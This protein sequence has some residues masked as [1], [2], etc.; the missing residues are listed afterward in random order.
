MKA[1]IVVDIPVNDSIEINEY[2]MV[3]DLKIR[4]MTLTDRKDLFI[5]MK[6]VNLKPMPEKKDTQKWLYLDLINCS[7]SHTDLVCAYVGY[8]KCI[9]EILGEEE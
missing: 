7:T 2:G 5:E 6:E 8:N 1:L 4:P 3:A 9:D